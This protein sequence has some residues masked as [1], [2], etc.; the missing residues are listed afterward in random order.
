MPETIGD[1][2]SQ[3][4][5]INRLKKKL[6]STRVN[7]YKAKKSRDVLKAKRVKTL[8]VVI[9]LCKTGRCDLTNQEIADLCFV[10]KKTVIE[11]RSRLRNGNNRT[12]QISS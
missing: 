4:D 12:S 5:E 2:F 11:I 3:Q 8:E 10:T 6:E 7:E 1:H 9:K